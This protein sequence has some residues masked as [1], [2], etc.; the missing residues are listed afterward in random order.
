MGASAELSGQIDALS[1]AYQEHTKAVLNY[2]IASDLFNDFIGYDVN[3]KGKIVP[4][5]TKDSRHIKETPKNIWK[6]S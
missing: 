4:K 2:N 3:E 6:E 1:Q 5:G